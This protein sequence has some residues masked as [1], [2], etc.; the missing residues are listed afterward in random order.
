MPLRRNIIILPLFMVLIVISLLTSSP[1]FAVEP[2]SMSE[3][4]AI[5]KNRSGGEILA[6]KRRVNSN[7]KVIYHIKVLTKKGVVRNVRIKAER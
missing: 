5:V 3:A 6:A 7:G 4:I 1:V 2:L